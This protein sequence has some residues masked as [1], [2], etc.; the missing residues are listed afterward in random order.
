M[1]RTVARTFKGALGGLEFRLPPSKM[2]PFAPNVFCDRN[3]GY[4]HPVT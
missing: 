2:Y 4:V 1:V 3:Y